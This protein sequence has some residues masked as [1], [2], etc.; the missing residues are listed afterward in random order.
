MYNL[1]DDY[2]LVVDRVIRYLDSTSI[3]ILEFGSIPKIIIYMFEGS[4]D[5]S[6]TNLKGQK[7]LKGC[8]F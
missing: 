6:F 4:S 3:Y 2:Y 1:S 7:N 8:Y 5:I